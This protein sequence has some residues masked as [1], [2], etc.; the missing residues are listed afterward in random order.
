MIS[1]QLAIA[2]AGRILLLTTSGAGLTPEITDL[3]SLSLF[4]DGE[5]SVTAT[6][7]D[8]FIDSSDNRFQLTSNST[9]FY[10]STFSP[11]NRSGWSMHLTGAVSIQVGTI[12]SFAFM[13]SSTAT[14]TVEFWMY[15]ESTA[16]QQ[17]SILGTNAAA[18]ANVGASLQITT[19]NK[20]QLLISNGTAA[21]CQ[22]TSTADVPSFTWTHIAVTYDQTTASN[23]AKLYI[24]GVLDS[25]TNKTANAPSARTTSTN[26]MTVGA[27]GSN[28]FT[29]KLSNLRITNN[30]VYSSNF[31]PSTST[32]AAIDGTQLLTLQNNRFIDNSVN[33]YTITRVAN[34]QIS[35]H[36]PFVFPLYTSATGGSLYFDGSNAFD[37]RTPS[38]AALVF[39]TGDFTV[40]CWLYTPAPKGGG[41]TNDRSIINGFFP[42]GAIRNFYLHNADNSLRFSD[43]TATVISTSVVPTNQWSHVAFV[44]AS[45]TL[46]MYINGLA[47]GSSSTF[48]TNFSLQQ[49]LVV[50]V[51]TGTNS[52]NMQGW[53]SDLRLV[54][55]RAVYTDNF[56]PP[57]TPL[58]A[59]N[60]TSLL[61]SFKNG[62]IV[63]KS[64]KCSIRPL[65]NASLTTAV[66]KYGNASYSFNGSTYLLINTPEGS[67]A[68]PTF[69]APNL[70]SGD[71]TVECWVNFTSFANGRA[72][73]CYGSSVAASGNSMA[74]VSSA[75]SRLSLFLSSAGSTWNIADNVEILSSASSSTWYHIAV[76]RSGSTFRTFA[77]GTTI[78]TFTSTLGLTTLANDMRIGGVSTG[79][80]TGYIDNLRIYRGY[81]KYTGDF[82]PE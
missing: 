60:G 67:S 22:T 77:N 27:L 7:N 23:N 44:R 78:R 11:Y 24:N 29:G 62:A 1:L 74:I 50:G 63:D 3:P 9:Q 76:T 69:G 66:K 54:K 17:R 18:V 55:G 40:E 12:S 30:I 34:A 16:T 2:A 28:Y 64:G 61:L 57:T 81:A 31:T 42:G 43:G 58:T 5:V 36:G 46:T 21:V 38:N 71:F 52:G 70:K 4:L 59:V 20:L 51:N 82:T 6:T 41:I 19:A 47:S 68:A 32:L 25:T 14:F 79:G 35:P 37:I 15:R 73:I 10:Q 48:T 53:M 80:I 56:T 33:N 45:N 49:P 39:G 75:T 8:T 72:I 13:H 65:P 26:V